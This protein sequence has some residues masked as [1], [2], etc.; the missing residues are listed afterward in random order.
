MRSPR[1]RRRSM[2]AAAAGEVASG[3]FD[4]R[5]PKRAHRCSWH[6]H[7]QPPLAFE[8]DRDGLRLD[9]DDAVAAAHIERDSG[10]ERGLVADLARDDEP[11]GR[12]HGSNHGMDHTMT[13]TNA[14]LDGQ[15]RDKNRE[16]GGLS[17][18]VMTDISH[19]HDTAAGRW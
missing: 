13:S 19:D 18:H 2:P 1:S 7:Q 10:F 15:E 6:G 17:V 3:P 14:G 16:R 4:R 9:F 8:R 12:I 5:G 11:P